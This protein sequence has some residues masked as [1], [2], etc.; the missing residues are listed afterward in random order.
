MLKRGLGFDQRRLNFVVS[1]PYHLSGLALVAVWASALSVATGAAGPTA[2]TAADVRIGDHPAYV[3]AVVDFVGGTLSFP[4]LQASEAPLFDG[5][6]SVRLSHAGVRTRARARAAYGV[7]VRVVGTANQLQIE[8]RAGK[9]RFKYLSYSVVGTNR[10]AMDLWKSAPPSSSAEL[11]S[12]LHGCL[13]LA[14]ARVH[15]GTVSASGKEHSVFEHQFQLAV[16][17]QNGY[18][19]A[20]RTVIASAGSWSAKLRYRVAHRQPATVEAVAFSPKDGALACLAQTRVSLTAS[21]APR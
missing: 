18:V 21:R 2:L 16:R 10:L 4:Q 14:S 12:G 15:A 19:L 7:G 8:I 13:T 20:H 9:A 3:R 6:T 5:S 11:R 17:A 1:P